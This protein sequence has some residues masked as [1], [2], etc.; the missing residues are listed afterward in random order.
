VHLR[1]VDGMPTIQQIELET[2]GD[3]PELDAD[4]FRELA[5][6]AKAVCAVSRA[7]RGVERITV[8]ASPSA[9]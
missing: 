5:E 6:R 4:G 3:V 2:K 7:L 1:L 8:A 9:A